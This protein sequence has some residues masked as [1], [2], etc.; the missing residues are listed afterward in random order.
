MGIVDDGVSPGSDWSRLDMRVTLDMVIVQRQ[1]DVDDD[2]GSAVVV[3]L[4]HQV[5]AGAGLDQRAADPGQVRMSPVQRTWLA[6]SDRARTA[7]SARR[8]RGTGFSVI[9]AAAGSGR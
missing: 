1:F 2:D 8:V 5:R 9:H 3:L 7:C 6:T 4:D